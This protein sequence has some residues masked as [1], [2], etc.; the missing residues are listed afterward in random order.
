MCTVSMNSVPPRSI[1]L[2]STPPLESRV[3]Y[4]QLGTAGALGYEGKQVSV[5]GRSYAHALSTHAPAQL[6][7]KIDGRF[8]TFKSQ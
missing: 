3:G 8:R 7:F 6:L 1:H 2:G 5:R 4:G